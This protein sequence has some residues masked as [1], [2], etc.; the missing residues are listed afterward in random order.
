MNSTDELDRIWRDGLTAAASELVIT[1]DPKARVVQRARHRRRARRAGTA[2]GLVVLSGSALAAVSQIGHDHTRTGVASQPGATISAVVQVE[3]APN[4]R[5]TIEF[6]G[7]A[8]S[9]APAALS[10]PSGLIRFEISGTPGH[11]LVIDGVS[12]VVA[13][14][15]P[16][17]PTTIT[18]DVQLAPGEYLMHC[19]VPGHAEA[20]EEVTLRVSP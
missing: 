1:G 8:T 18:R 6:P 20:G 14:F 3:D 10:L 9:G 4:G 19:I 5:L 7:R 16:S 17:G 12:G 13:D 2:V 15:T 11:D